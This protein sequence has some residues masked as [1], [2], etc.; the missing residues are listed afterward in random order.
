MNRDTIQVSPEAQAIFE[1]TMAEADTKIIPE[2]LFQ[3]IVKKYPLKNG[4]IS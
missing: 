3:M 4:T 2:H 1:Q